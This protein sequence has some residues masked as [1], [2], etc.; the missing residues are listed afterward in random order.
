MYTIKDAMNEAKER[1]K[2]RD[3]SQR[4]LAA[5]AQ[6]ILREHREAEADIKRFVDLED[7]TPAQRE[8]LKNPPPS[9]YELTCVLPR[10]REYEESQE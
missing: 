7:L 9:E 10:Y 5:V 3:L 2:D 8:E 4:V 1:Y 6:D